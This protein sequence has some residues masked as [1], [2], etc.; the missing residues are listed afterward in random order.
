MVV[1]GDHILSTEDGDEQ[2]IEVA[3]INENPDYNSRTFEN[4]VCV[5]KLSSS[6]N[7]GGNVQAVNLPAPMSDVDAGVMVSVSGWGTTSVSFNILVFNSSLFIL[8]N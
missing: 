5:L 3:S 1:A 8:L 4:D 7:L 6:I 2:V